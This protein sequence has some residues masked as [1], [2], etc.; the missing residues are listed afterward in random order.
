[1]KKTVVFLL[2]IALIALADVAIMIGIQ[3]TYYDGMMSYCLYVPYYYVDGQ[4][5]YQGE[6]ECRE[7]VD[8]ARAKGLYYNPRQITGPGFDL[9]QN[10]IPGVDG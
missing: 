4:P 2:L 3:N 7:V 8:D 6:S 9:P 10:T 5:F 1:M